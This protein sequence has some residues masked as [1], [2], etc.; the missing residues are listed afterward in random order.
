MAKTDAQRRA[1]AK[2]VKDK[3]KVYQLR[4]YPADMELFEYFDSQENKAAYLKELIRKDM[5]GGN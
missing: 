5:E 3:V 4:F 2:Y 1:T